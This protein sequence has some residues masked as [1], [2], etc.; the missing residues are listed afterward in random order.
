VIGL[1]NTLTGD[2]LC[3]PKHPVVLERIEFPETVISMAIE[4]RTAADRDRL[5]EALAAL[6]RQDPTF[7]TRVDPETGQ[8]LI[9][10]MGELHLEV[11]VDR[12][13]RDMKVGVTVGTPRV[14][15][16]ETVTTRGE[17]D[18]KFVRQ[19]GGRGQFAVVRLAV[20]PLDLQ[21]T[22]SHLHVES[23]VRDGH[24]SQPYLR[25]VEAGIREA[26]NSGVVA[27]YPVIDLNVTI[28]DGK[29]HEVDSS[30]LAFEHAG[31]LAFELA[32]QKA[33]PQLLEPIMKVE[34][35]VP[36]ACFGNVNADLSG[37]RAMITH[38]DQHGDRR[39]IH[40]QVP[41]ANMFGYATVIRSLTQGRAGWAMEP[42][43][44]RPA[45]REVAAALLEVG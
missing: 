14:S 6:S 28:L 10:G 7:Q 23:Q 29:E 21:E 15:Y 35:A 43:H 45:P 25:A 9:S 17:A 20:E 19:T 34:I 26:A 22:D 18:G 44:Y 39:I 40:A 2:T 11:L 5:G 30:E 12:L 36:E 8:T 37:R 4:P 33:Q 42:S 38:T 41:L 24:I 31:R 13:Q 32:M 1:R 16:R 3:D 27:G